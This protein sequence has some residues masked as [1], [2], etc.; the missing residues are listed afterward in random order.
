MIASNWRLLGLGLFA[1][2]FGQESSDDASSSECSSSSSSSSSSQQQQQQQHAA[3]AGLSSSAASC[4]AW[5]WDLDSEHKCNVRRISIQELI[6]EFKSGLP[7]LYHEPL[8]I[9]NGNNDYTAPSPFTGCTHSVFEAKSS[10]ENITRNLPENFN[11]TLSSSN[12]F[13]AHRRTIPLTQYLNDTLS[14]E[15]FPN[16]LSNETW[17]LFGE[18]YS[19]DWQQMMAEFCLPPCQTCTKELCALAFG[20]GGKGSGVQWHTHGPGF[21]QSIHGRKHWVLYPPHQ[22]PMYDPDYTSRYW[23]EEIY[24]NLDDEKK[25]YEC[26]LFP[27]EMI[28]FPD[29]WHHATINLDRYTAFLSTFTT[30]HGF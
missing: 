12:S 16:Q 13:S 7:P 25:P 26:T 11:V 24:M 9:F 19:D 23:M 14:K 2:A 1:L 8:L 4:T 29:N 15:T 27:G 20:I 21:S 28:Y 10:L 3:P 5:K 30:E 22:K 6:K 18:T 17:Y